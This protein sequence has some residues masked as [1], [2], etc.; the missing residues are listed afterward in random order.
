M[1][2]GAG[3]LALSMAIA[4]FLD[5]YWMLLA[6]WFAVGMAYSLAQ[7]PSGR[8]LRRSAHEADRPAIYAAQFALSHACWLVTYP[9]AGR[10]GNLAG[11]SATA[12]VLAGIAGF[13]TAVAM[14]LWP[15]DDPEEI[16]HQHRELPP[17]HPHLK[18]GER[19]AQK[20][21]RHA[22]VIDE[23]HPTWPTSH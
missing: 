17:D 7:V 10:F 2:A 12:L 4:V 11:L 19:S 6:L 20:R 15:A 14:W 13:A 3:L 5:S 9:L 1:L 18:K 16:E 8:L 23:L 21:H 22:Y